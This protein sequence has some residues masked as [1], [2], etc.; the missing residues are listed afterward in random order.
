MDKAGE[1]EVRLV[2]VLGHNQLASEEEAVDKQHMDKRTLQRST[3]VEDTEDMRTDM[4]LL[5]VVVVG[6]QELEQE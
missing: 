2:E 1:S 6:Q 5:V 3:V 4:L